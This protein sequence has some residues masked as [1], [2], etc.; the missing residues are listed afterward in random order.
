MANTDS[1]TTGWR[2]RLK[3]WSRRATVIAL[4]SVGILAFVAWSLRSQPV[5]VDIASVVRGDLIVSVDDEGE[6]RVQNAYV[7]SAP[8]AGRVERITL[9]AGDPVVAEE[10]VL[11]LFQPQD[12]ALLDARARSEAEAGV[13]LAEAEQARARAEL[14]FARSELRRAEQLHKNATIS[15][16][17]LDKARLSERTAQAALDQATTT[18]AQRQ[19]DLEHARSAIA[20]ASSGRAP[21]SKG[22]LVAVRAPVSGRILRRLQQSEGLLPAGTPLLEI[23]DP[24]SLEIVSD[25]LSADAV[26]VHVGDGVV[27]EEWGGPAPL[28]GT[29]KRVEPFGFTKVS[30]LGIEEQR[31]N[32]ITDFASPPDQWKSLG[33]GYRV[34]TRIIIERRSKVLKVPVGALF[35]TGQDWSVFVNDGGAKSG[36]ALLRRVTLGV[37]NSLEAEVVE[38]LKDDERVVVHPSDQVAD[39]VP[40]EPREM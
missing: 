14:A 38:G 37:R 20:R 29:V 12:P 21:V 1:F 6:T 35:R 2:A 27:I 25:F 24:A 30:A 15:E 19:R 7:V 31:V 16:S 26:K 18:L 32:I 11:A 10:T 3:G 22:A 36:V 4:M 13:G 5:A 33:H 23:G 39:R 9:E 40:V 28:L 8:V 34:M 17:G